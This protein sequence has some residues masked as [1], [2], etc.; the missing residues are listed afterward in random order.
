M[1]T[2]KVFSFSEDQFNKLVNS[3]DKNTN[4]ISTTN[5]D[6][7][8][9][10]ELWNLKKK[11]IRTE[12]HSDFLI[13]YCKKGM[14]PKGLQVRNEPSLFV[15]NEKFVETWTFIANRCSRDWLLL[16]IETAQATLIIEKVELDEMERKLK[17]NTTVEDAKLKLEEIQ[18]D[19]DSYKDYLINK[20]SNK[21][22]KD[23][24]QYKPELVYPYLQKD[25][26]ER[27]R[28][29]WPS[30]NNWQT[31]KR[32]HFRKGVTFSDTSYTSSESENELT[33]AD[34]TEQNKEGQQKQN[35]ESLDFLDRRKGNRSQNPNPNPRG[36]G[37]GRGYHQM[38]QGQQRPYMK[39]RSQKT[40]D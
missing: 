35:R 8:Q 39:T 24:N 26:F 11:T 31:N 17:D 28:E 32:Q 23:L 3:S 36:R 25:Y 22:R 27:P 7:E 9:W 4:T 5:S 29:D 38:N 40:W 19:L 16:I 2:F 14:I 10:K 21:F 20:K 33:P 15:K 34:H 1:D 6:T 13:Q 37:R 12:L 18:K 30:K